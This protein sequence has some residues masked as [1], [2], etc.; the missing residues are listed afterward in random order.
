MTKEYEQSLFATALIHPDAPLPQGLIDPQGRPAP[1]RFDVYR[2]NVTVGLVRNLEA[3]FP[4][5]HSLVGDDFFN[6]MAQEFARAHP[7]KSRIMML[8]GDDFADFIQGFTPAASLGYLP[9][10]ARLEQAMRMSYHAADG[11]PTA[12]FAALDEAQF[13]AARAQFAPAVCLITS[14]WPIHSI[15]HAALHGGTPPVMATQSVLILRPE[16]DVTPHLL[17]LGAEQFLHELMAGKTIG[18]AINAAPDFELTATLSLLISGGA[19]TH[20]N[21]S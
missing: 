15:W 20:L 2:N 17:P 5:V 4:A 21:W 3:G 10:V 9:D 14:P 6:A 1:R 18:D 19:I 11:G 12:D 16:F 13:I 7:P 8:Y